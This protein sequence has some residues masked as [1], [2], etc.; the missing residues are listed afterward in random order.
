MERVDTLRH[1][2]EKR[3]ITWLATDFDDTLIDTKALFIRKMQIF[4]Q[5]IGEMVGESSETV[6]DFMAAALRQLRREFHVH[7]TLLHETG[8]ITALRFRNER[9]VVDF[10]PQFDDLLTVYRSPVP[11]F[12]SVS[13]TLN[14]LRESGLRLALVT[15]A[16]QDWTNIKLAGAGL[17]QTFD[18]VKSI[19]S[20]IR[21]DSDA[22][23]RALDSAG[24]AMQNVLVVGDSWESDV[25]PVLSLG[26]PTEHVIRVGGETLFP[27][28]DPIPGVRAITSFAHLP[29][30]LLRT[31][32]NARQ[33]FNLF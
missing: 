26:V 31:D 9:E 27:L 6:F 13:E 32:F 14:L 2:F 3:G 4:S 30:E 16:D 15:N 20:Y 23:K 28:N 5:S 21:K 10:G 7:P 8:R 33:S 19:P 24:I 22:W 1:L 25:Q 11:V 12:E 17:L 18:A 29:E